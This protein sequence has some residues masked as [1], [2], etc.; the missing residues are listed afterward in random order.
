M[1]ENF[2]EK[3]EQ[4]EPED[5][6]VELAKVKSSPA[7][8]IVEEDPTSL[9]MSEQA[10]EIEGQLTVD[11]YQDNEDIVV[12]STVAGVSPDDLDIHITP[13]SVTVK[14]SR[15]KSQ[16][17]EDKDYFYQECFWGRFSRS[18]ILPVEVDPE[19]STAIVKNGVLTVRMPR[20][21]RQKGKKVKVKVD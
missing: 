13:E 4:K 15:E 10:D 20:L 8:I 1:R 19:K 16:K 3:E 6:F 2:D 7:K 21:N 18:V 11:V 17:I 14:G 9:A 12:Q 5:I